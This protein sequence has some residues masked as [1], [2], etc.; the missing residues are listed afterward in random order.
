MARML[1][2]FSAASRMRPKIGLPNSPSNHG[3][4][5]TD[6]SQFNPNMAATTPNTSS[7]FPHSG[8]VPIFQRIK[9]SNKV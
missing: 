6:H 1:V 2:D 8:D 7:C 5:E 4:K 3:V 9:V